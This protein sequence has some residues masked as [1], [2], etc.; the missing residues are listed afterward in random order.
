MDPQSLELAKTAG[1]AS[2]M[3]AAMAA[4]AYFVIDILSKIPIIG[5]LFFCVNGLMVLAAYF[6]ISYLV[7]GKLTAFPPGQSVSTLALYV[8][9]GVAA[10]TTA[11]FLVAVAIAGVIGLLI[12]SALNGSSS[13]FGSTIGGVVGLIISI[14]AWA[15]GGM[16]VGGILSFLGSYLVLNRSQGTQTTAS[17]PF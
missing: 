10:V 3:Y 15:I 2:L 17:R 6:G 14:F 5:L 9:L 12:G 11:A 4:G 7:T 1:R 16:I 13:A 8:G